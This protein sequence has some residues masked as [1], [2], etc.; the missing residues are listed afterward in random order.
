MKYGEFR[1]HP[2]TKTVIEYRIMGNYGYGW[3]VEFASSCEQ[4]AR[5]NYSLYPRNGCGEYRFAEARVPNPSYGRF[6]VGQRVKIHESTV[7]WAEG[8]RYGR[9]TKIG[10]KYVTV[11]WTE[12][13]EVTSRF[14]PELIAPEIG[15]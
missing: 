1:N 13:P 12:S 5:S 14:I 11:V 15:T 9:V 10:R 7:R 3:E 4:A 8:F 2:L 6:Y